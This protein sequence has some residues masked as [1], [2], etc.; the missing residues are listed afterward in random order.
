MSHVRKHK[1]GLTD[2][3]YL[4]ESL[5]RIKN[6]Y[7]VF[8]QNIILPQTETR[9]ASFRWDGEGYTLFYDADF[10]T[11][12]LSVNSFTEKV[13]CEYSAEE[14]VHSMN[15]FGFRP[16]LYTDSVNCNKYQTIKSKSLILT[17][18]SY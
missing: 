8:G 1:L 16:E 10:W 6:N 18:Y 13:R 9:S 12:T 17:R 2:F 15:N 5:K 7:H 11:N 14:V 3:K 4:K